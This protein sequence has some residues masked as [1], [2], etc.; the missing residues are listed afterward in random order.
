[1]TH[2]LEIVVGFHGNHLSLP[3]FFLLLFH[4][5]HLVDFIDKNVTQINRR[6]KIG[7][8]IH[9]V[10]PAIGIRLKHVLLTGN[11]LISNK[12]PGIFQVLAHHH[13]VGSRVFHQIPYRCTTSI[14][15][16]IATFKPHIGIVTRLKIRVDS[17]NILFRH[18]V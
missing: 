12:I 10:N 11:N 1:M 8:G 4:V 3:L 17:R 15:R 16:D 2:Q 7:S 14:Q 6:I 18:H 13:L 5:V 9:T